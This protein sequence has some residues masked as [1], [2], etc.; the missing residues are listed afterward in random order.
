MN[1]VPGNLSRRDMLASVLAS[2]CFMAMPGLAADA[3]RY[4]PQNPDLLFGTVSSIWGN[5]VETVV[6]HAARLRFQGVEFFRRNVLPYIDSPGH[7][8]D[9]YHKVRQANLGFIDVANGGPGMA[10]NFIDPA[11]TPKTIAE[12]VAFARDLLAP[13]HCDVWK[14][15][16]G[17]RPADNIMTDDHLKTL[18]DALNKIGEQTIK[19]GI[20]LAPHPHVWGPL[21]R[22]H[23]VRRMFELTDPKYVWWT[24]D[25]GHLVVGGMDP[26]KMIDDYFTRLAQVHL[27]DA[28][29]KY[30][31]NKA[32]PTREDNAKETVFRNLGKGV[33]D[34]PAVFKILRDRHFKGWV[35]FDL[36]PDDPNA[37]DSYLSAIAYLKNAVGLKWPPPRA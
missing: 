8:M 28:P 33:T 26:V 17:G 3:E 12:H 29:A 34:F 6:T 5:D 11:K 20:R 2:S 15:T 22:E 10:E 21:E 4:D 19:Y 23:E 7:F 24:A 14:I 16:M 35:T 13:T 36:D 9:L 27:K 30:K 37:D 1:N 25:T 18:A 31:N 32:T